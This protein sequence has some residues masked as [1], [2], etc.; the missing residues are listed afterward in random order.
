MSQILHLATAD[1]LTRLLPMVAAY[2]ASE[3]I[4]SDEA[5]REAALR[6]LLEGSPHGAIWLIGPKIAPVGYVCVSFGWSLELGGLDG[7]VDELWIREKVRGRG[8]GSDAIVALQKALRDAGL[9]GLSLEVAEGNETAARL[10]KRAGF[11][12][13]KHHLMTWTAARS[14]D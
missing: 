11:R 7:I 10:Y 8:M 2:H 14:A 13:R 3:G 12:D 6:P 4:E 5:H 9:C 1:D